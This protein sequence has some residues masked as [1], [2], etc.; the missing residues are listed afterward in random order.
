MLLLFIKR[1]VVLNLVI[2]DLSRFSAILVNLWNVVCINTFIT[3]LSK[4]MLYHLISQVSKVATQLV[5]LNKFLQALDDSK[6]IRVVFFDV[7]KAIEC[8]I[9]ACC[10]N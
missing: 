3:I 4:T 7:S 5:Y 9:R 6:E 1:T 8:G 2:T 10:S